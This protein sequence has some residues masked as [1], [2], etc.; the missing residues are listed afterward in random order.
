MVESP[1]AIDKREF[2]FILFKKGMLRH[3]GFKNEDELEAF[4]KELA[5]SDAYY[6]CAYYEEPEA[7]IAEAET[8][9]KGAEPEEIGDPEIPSE[10]PPIDE[11]PKITKLRQAYEDGRISKDLYEKNLSKLSGK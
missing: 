1:K 3:K 10:K 11:D 7:E 4:L 6:S 2:G 8:E 9:V 5:P